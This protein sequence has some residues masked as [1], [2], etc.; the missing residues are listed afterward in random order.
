VY[1]TGIPLMFTNNRADIMSENYTAKTFSKN[2]TIQKMQESYA[3]ETWALK[4]NMIKKLMIFE[5][6]TMRISGPTR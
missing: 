5:R 3:T 4:E 6:K 1:I 2:C